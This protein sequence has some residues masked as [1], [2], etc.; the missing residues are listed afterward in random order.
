MKTAIIVGATGLIGKE[1][2]NQLLEDNRYDK[3]KLLVRKRQALTHSKIEEI[4]IDFNNLN[5]L[6]VTGDELY[7]CLGT[8]IKTAGSKEAFYKVDFEYVVQIAKHALQAGVE[9]LVV[10]SAMGA[11]K[12]SSV[13]YNNVKGE[14]EEAVSQ[15]GFQKCVIIRPSM[16]LGNRTEFRLAELITKKVMTT[17]SFLIPAKY[18]A[19]HDY[20]V[21][22]AMI[23]N[24][25]NSQLKVLIVE[26]QDMLL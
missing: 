10:V 5:E 2:C 25:N 16:L 9:Q 8:T 24:C 4:I 6:N 7:C 20:Q 15:L 17:L 11:D 23:F 21:A 19:I 3:I 12:N 14:M 1:L 13:F 22:K 26:N 18:K